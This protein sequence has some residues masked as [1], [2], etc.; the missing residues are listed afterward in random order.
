MLI[1]RKINKLKK[2]K[3]KFL[4]QAHDVKL[5]ENL[6]PITKKLDESTT[7]ISEVIKKSNSED[8]KRALPNSSTF[9]KLLQEMIGSLMNSR[10]SLK[11][12]KMN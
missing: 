3:N 11:I 10:N 7:K 9:S 2:I 1:N 6:S 8:D 5:A 4:K 12:L